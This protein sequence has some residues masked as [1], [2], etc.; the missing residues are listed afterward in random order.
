MKPIRFYYVGVIAFLTVAP[1]KATTRE[2]SL[3]FAVGNARAKKRVWESLLVRDSP[4]LLHFPAIYVGA[5]APGC[6]RVSLT[7]LDSRA[8]R[9]EI[10][11]ASVKA[12]K[13]VGP[14]VFVLNNFIEDFSSQPN[15]D[16]LLG[17]LRKRV[18]EPIQKLAW[19]IKG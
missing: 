5:P 15:F 11:W 10:L 9:P 4:P 6:A 7:F 14:S 1:L 18:I 2:M 8:S 12:G 13:Q 16:E 19:V 17:L 3:Q